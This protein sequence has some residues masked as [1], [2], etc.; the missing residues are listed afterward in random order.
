MTFLTPSL[1]AGITLI[2][3]PIV[4]HLI[5]RRKPRRMEFPALRFLEA[6]RE[7]NQRQL[8]LRHLLLLLLRMAAILFLAV[9][10]ARPSVKFSGVP[11]QSEGAGGGGTGLRYVD[12]D[13]IHPREPAPGWRRPRISDFGS[14]GSC[15]RRARSPCSTRGA[16]PTTF[17]AHRGAARHRIEQLATTAAAQPMPDRAGRGRAASWQDQQAGRPGVVRVHRP[18]QGRRLAAWRPRAAL[19]GMLAS[20]PGDR[21]LRDR[22]RGGKA[23]R[24]RASSELR[25]VRI[26]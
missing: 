8:Q 12:A 19:Q 22:R 7:T 5:M 14:S 24:T 26:R 11:G 13:G 9:A 3:L 16:A 23:G 21:H 2:G 20:H 10:L 18:G 25:I 6:R 17:Q 4:L 15:P 1:L